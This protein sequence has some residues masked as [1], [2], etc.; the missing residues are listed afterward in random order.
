MRR[1]RRISG[2]LYDEDACIRMLEDQAQHGWFLK[3][4]GDLWFIFE[5][6]EAR[7]MHYYIDYN[8]ND[9]E[10]SDV[11]K[12]EGYQLAGVRRTV[13]IYASEEEKEPLQTDPVVKKMA[14]DQVFPLSDAILTGV[15][16][17]LTIIMAH[18]AIDPPDRFAFYY[19]HTEFIIW[20]VLVILVVFLVLDALSLLLVRYSIRK[21]AEGI[22]VKLNWLK[23][24]F[25]AEEAAAFIVLGFVLVMYWTLFHDTLIRI[26]FPLLL[27]GSLWAA[28]MVMNRFIGTIPDNAKRGLLTAAVVVLLLGFRFFLHRQINTGTTP[29]RKKS[30]EIQTVLE[31]E[32]FTETSN[33]WL[34]KISLYTIPFGREETA[35]VC[36]DEKVAET[37]FRR[38]I[39]YGLYIYEP[40]QSFIPAGFSGLEKM[41]TKA[42]LQ[43][44]ETSFARYVSEGD[45]VYRLPP[46]PNEKAIVVCRFG[47]TVI[48]TMG[49]Q[50][51]T[52][53]VIRFHQ[54]TD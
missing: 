21:K 5:K 6:G 24:W 51:F 53:E 16:A 52:D 20:A 26:L 40:E 9:P 43:P 28:R 10:Y 39:Q 47:N 30:T 22:T 29:E 13:R 33:P 1:F 45:D 19:F 8:Y 7:P 11:L 31:S 2:Y 41:L 42:H 35:V 46:E 49:D 4:I 15:L 25:F 44:Y 3:S 36:R 14:L 23:Y 37:V 18:G 12:A 34:Q 50:E 48:L 38:F 17:F 54:N 32:F 27:V